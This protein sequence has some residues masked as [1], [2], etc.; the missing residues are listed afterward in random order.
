MGNVAAYECLANSY[1]RDIDTRLGLRNQLWV[2]PYAI[3]ENSYNTSEYILEGVA[4]L[5]KSSGAPR[6]AAI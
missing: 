4:L 2:Q 3:R 5:G 1:T 6:S